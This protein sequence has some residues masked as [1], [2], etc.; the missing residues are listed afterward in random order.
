LVKSIV[1]LHGG[2]ASIESEIARGTIVRLRFP[3]PDSAG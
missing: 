3:N 1:E 2:S